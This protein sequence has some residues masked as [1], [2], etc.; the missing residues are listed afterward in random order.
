M[1]FTMGLV[2]P[3]IE[4]PSGVSLH[5]E[6]SGE[7]FPLVF[8]HGWSMSARVWRYQAE[9]LASLYRVVT[10]DLRGH[11]ESSG[12]FTG[13]SFEDYAADIVELFTILDLRDT[14]IIG[15]SMGA[16]IALQAFPLLADRVRSL[17]LVGGNAKFTASEDYPFGLPRSETRN[18][19]IRLKKNYMKT[20]GDFFNG[21]FAEGELSGEDYQHIVR[22]I[23]M[24]GK[25]PEPEAALKTLD[26]LVS[27]DLRH[28]LPGTD[29]PV[30]LIHGS[31]DVIAPSGASR[32]MLR[33]LPHATL[34]IVDGAG[35]APFLSRSD[36]FNSMLRSFLEEVYGGD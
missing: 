26:M 27:S 34:K 25:L 8:L 30:L 16:Q 17:V 32:H 1:L 36:D 20:M 6:S 22:D 13:L 23:V 19:A 35:H 9:A 5:Y 31:E 12:N 24:G 2:M 3:F 7:G 21:M 28:V 4:T 18:M 11:G 14:S 33:Q 29:A 15:W 10:V